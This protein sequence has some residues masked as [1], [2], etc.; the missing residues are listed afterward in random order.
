MFAKWIE[1]DGR[2]AFADTDNGGVRLAAAEVTA[3]FTGQAAGQRIV[4]GPDGRPTL[5]AP[6]APT[7]EQLAASVRSQRDRLLAASDWTQLP[8]AP[9]AVA[10]R[11]VAYRQ[12]LRD[13]TGQAGF[14]AA[15]V[16]PAPPA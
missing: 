3:L 16:W 6:P 9:A 14:P 5:A 12:A 11:W 1:P 4:R 10:A 8:D 7:E 13:V 15:V 2:F